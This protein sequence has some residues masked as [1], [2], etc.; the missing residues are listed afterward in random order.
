MNMGRVTMSDY[1]I[2]IMHIESNPGF[3]VS[4]TLKFDG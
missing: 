4:L 1:V 3:S 2:N